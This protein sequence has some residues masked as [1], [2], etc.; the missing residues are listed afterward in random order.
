M[1]NP[2]QR[3]GNEVPAN[4]SYWTYRSEF[5]QYMVRHG[6]GVELRIDELAE[7]V[8]QR[9]NLAAHELP[10]HLDEQGNLIPVQQSTASL[11]SVDNSQ[12]VLQ[13]TALDADV[14][15]I[16]EPGVQ[17]TASNGSVDNL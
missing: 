4:L 9:P 1:H 3:S 6:L 14:D 17:S 11:A 13:P 7:I 5:H 12:P 8:K 2:T 10:R 16:Q 15:N